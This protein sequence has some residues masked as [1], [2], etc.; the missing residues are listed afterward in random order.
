MKKGEVVVIRV[1]T[2]E[3][4]ALVQL[5]GRLIERYYPALHTVSYCIEEQPVGICSPETKALAVPKIIDLAK[6]HQDADA[7]VVSCCDD[8]AVEELRREVPAPIIG[9]G[10]STCAVARSFAGRPGVLGITDYVPQPYEA[11]F[12]KRLI[13][14][15]RP[16]GVSCTLDLMQAGGRE[17]VLA[18]AMELKARGA[19]C[20]VLACT[21]MST[22]GIAG[23]I[24]DACGLPV[25]D[26]VMAEG[27]LAYYAC[28]RKKK[29]RE[30][31]DIVC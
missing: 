12:G 15:G 14:L 19:D 27:L 5:H 29:I 10:S 2:L 28:L 16:D 13:Y 4:Q 3:D 26:P 24:E 18:K 22:I 25:V 17:S 11:M 30:A 21:G 9:A 31:G 20:I 8:P 1:V 7:I 23:A 6:A